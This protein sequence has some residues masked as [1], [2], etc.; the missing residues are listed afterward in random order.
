M[1]FFEKK[2][3]GQVCIFAYGQTGSG[4]TY[5]MMGPEIPKESKG[6]IPRSLKQIFETSQTLAAQG[7][8]FKMQVIYLYQISISIKVFISIMM[9]WH[10]PI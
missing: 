3:V 2:N 10:L 4:K 1:I 5:T 8:E 6:L 7:W 9:T